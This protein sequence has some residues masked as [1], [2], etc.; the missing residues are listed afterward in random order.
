M[1][2]AGRWVPLETAN[3]IFILWAVAVAVLGA[4]VWWVSRGRPPRNPTKEAPARRRRG[5]HRK[6]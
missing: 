4:I 6:R 1:Y 5:K 2:I 3:T